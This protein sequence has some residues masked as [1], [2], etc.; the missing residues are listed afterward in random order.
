MAPLFFHLPKVKLK[1]KMIFPLFKYPGGGGKRNS[2]SSHAPLKAAAHADYLLAADKTS[3]LAGYCAVISE[4]STTRLGVLD[5]ARKRRS[6]R[7]LSAGVQS[8]RG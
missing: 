7:A 1:K 8:T 5:L 4:K 6:C 2:D 3:S